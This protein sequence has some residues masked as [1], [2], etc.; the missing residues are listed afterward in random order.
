MPSGW[1]FYNQPDN[2]TLRCNKNNPQDGWFVIQ[3][4]G[5]GVSK[6][7]HVFF[8][9]TPVVTFSS[10]PSL[11]ANQSG[12]AQV[13]VNPAYNPNSPYTSVNYI[14]DHG[15]RVNG[16]TSYSNGNTGD[17]NNAGISTT[18]WGG[19]LYVTATNACGTSPSISTVIGPPYIIQATVNGVPDNGGSNY[20]SSYANLNL[21]SNATSYTWTTLNGTSS[22]YPATN[23][24]TAYPNPFMRVLGQTSNNFGNGENHTFYV[25]LNGCT[26]YRTAYPNP[27]KNLL[28]VEFDDAQMAQDLVKEVALYNQKGK[29]VKQ[30]SG[31]EANTKAYFKQSRSVVFDVHDLP[32]D[33]YFLHVQMGDKLYKEQIIVE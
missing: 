14:S 23:S 30:L 21:N 26:G 2:Y 9:V 32:K 5:P 4:A 11:Y 18:G 6:T 28:T 16:G 7:M 3:I 24:A 33:T 31:A 8:R 17:Y 22:L 10:L 1:S 19:N 15:L 25:M 29:A 27:T 20:V 12:T 13:Y